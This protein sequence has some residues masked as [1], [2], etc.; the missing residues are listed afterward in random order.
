MGKKRIYSD[1]EKGEI[2]LAQTIAVLH[3]ELRAIKT[4]IGI[5]KTGHVP[6]SN[7]FSK[8]FTGLYTSFLGHK[9]EGWIT[10]C[11]DNHRSPYRYFAPE[12]LLAYN[13]FLG[14]I[15]HYYTNSTYNEAVRKAQAEMGSYSIKFAE[16]YI[17]PN[18]FKTLTEEEK[19]RGFNAVMNKIG[20]TATTVYRAEEVVSNYEAPE[21]R[22]NANNRVSATNQKD[23]VTLNPNKAEF[24]SPAE[25]DGE[26]TLFGSGMA[27]TGG[28]FSENGKEL[29]RGDNGKLYLNGCLYEGDVLS[30]EGFLLIPKKE[31]IEK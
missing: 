23:V 17:N 18:A 22:V 28:M 24:Y 25:L 9:H 27:Y 13:Q 4:R 15:I 8:L 26:L 1:I 29:T 19:N 7:D 31:D 16:H 10:E 21:L 12:T 6:S 20:V 11:S 30:A 2:V 3:S 5:N 14:L